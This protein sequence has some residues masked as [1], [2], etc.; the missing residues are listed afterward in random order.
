MTRRVAFQVAAQSQISADELV[1]QGRALL[2]LSVGERLFLA[3][4]DE[5]HGYLATII[6]LT[7]YGHEMPTLYAGLTGTVGIRL[8]EPKEITWKSDLV[9]LDLL[10]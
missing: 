10:L 5:P 4:P 6:A 8:A 7:S 1:L 3:T 9:E 2:D